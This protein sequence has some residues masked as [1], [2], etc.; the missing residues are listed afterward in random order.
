MCLVAATNTTTASYPILTFL[1]THF[2]RTS[3]YQDVYRA[4]YAHLNPLLNDTSYATWAARKEMPFVREHFWAI[5]AEGW[6]RP[7]SAAA[8]RSVRQPYC[9]GRKASLASQLALT[10]MAASPG[11]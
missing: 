9:P 6:L 11:G 10:S 2:T 1:V 5:V 4:I 7:Q 8:E 3:T